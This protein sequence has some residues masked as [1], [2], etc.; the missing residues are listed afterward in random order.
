MYEINTLLK[1]TQSLQLKRKKPER[2]IK[3][4]VF[5]MFTS[6]GVSIRLF[7]P[8]TDTVERRGGNGKKVSVFPR[9]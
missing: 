8:H 3:Q 2:Q 1:Y 9:N 4:Q 7:V 5:G 6:L